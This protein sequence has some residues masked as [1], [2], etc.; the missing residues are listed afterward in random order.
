MPD[1]VS[2]ETT[3]A[4]SPSRSTGWNCFAETK[5][6]RDARQS[7]GKVCIAH[8]VQS[9]N[10]SAAFCLSKIAQV[11]ICHASR[12]SMLTEFWMFGEAFQRRHRQIKEDTG[13]A[14]PTPWI[15]DSY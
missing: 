2:V 11:H 10:P 12:W 7:L 5:P 14:M 3:D 4:Q 1:L 8:A 13:A 6:R 9:E 15:M